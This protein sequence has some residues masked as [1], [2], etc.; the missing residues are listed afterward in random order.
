VESTRSLQAS[1]VASGTVTDILVEVG[2]HVAKGDVVAKL[3]SVTDDIVRLKA[4]MT[5]TVSDVSMAVGQTVGNTGDTSVSV[6]GD[7]ASAAGASIQVTDVSDLVVSADFSETDASRLRVGQRANVTFDALQR[8]V[9]AEV[10]DIDLMSTVVNNV[11]EYG[12]TLELAKI[13]AKLKPGQTATVEVVTQRA[14][15]AL[16]VPSATVQTAGGQSVVTVTRNGQ[17][18]QVTVTV[19]IEGDQTTQILSG[20]SEGD[21]VVIPTTTGSNGFPDGGFPGGGAIGGGP[22]AVNGPGGN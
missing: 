21:Q 12:V 8:S 6:V 10:R 3:E 11:V 13:P 15:N 1:F 19:G 9:D 2:D 16:F 18:A 4:P 22:I 14:R 7:D 5:G 20:L 17:Q